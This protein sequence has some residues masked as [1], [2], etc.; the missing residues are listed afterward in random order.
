VVV[1]VWSCTVVGYTADLER[2]GVLYTS[3]LLQATTRLVRVRPP[4]Y[5]GESVAAYRRSWLHEDLRGFNV[6][7]S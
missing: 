1:G 2:A 5:S 6:A 4:A 3:L 7:E